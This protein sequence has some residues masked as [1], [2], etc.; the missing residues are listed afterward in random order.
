MYPVFQQ[1]LSDNGEGELSS[2]VSALKDLPAKEALDRLIDLLELTRIELDDDQIK[3]L[4]YGKTAQPELESQS[5]LLDVLFVDKFGE[6][7][8]RQFVTQR[9]SFLGVNT[10]K[11]ISRYCPREIF[12]KFHGI[13]DQTLEIIEKALN[14]EGLTFAEDLPLLEE[15]RIF[16]LAYRR[17]L[18][19]EHEQMFHACGFMKVGSLKELSRVTQTQFVNSTKSYYKSQ[20]RHI[21]EYD[22]EEEKLL[23]NSAIEAV[24]HYM[25]FLKIEFLTEEEA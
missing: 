18:T 20:L 19:R 2:K 4:L 12:A 14:E 6:K 13:G 15:H 9:L 10:V 22:V 16:P 17:N 1:F 25:N 5:K 24:Q 11:D 23:V 3:E 7:N 8:S 21:G